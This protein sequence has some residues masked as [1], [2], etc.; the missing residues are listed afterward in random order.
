MLGDSF[1]S[2]R[3]INTNGGGSIATR[4]SSVLSKII[5]KS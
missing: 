3:S 5:G 2:E 1:N 4:I